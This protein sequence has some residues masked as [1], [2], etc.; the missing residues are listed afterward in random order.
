MKIW[1][2]ETVIFVP[3]LSEFLGCHGHVPDNLDKCLGMPIRRPH[4]GTTATSRARMSSRVETFVIVCRACSMP[5]GNAI[6]IATC[7][8]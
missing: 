4:I 1:L 8:T 6:R 3:S 2:S 5:R 7:P